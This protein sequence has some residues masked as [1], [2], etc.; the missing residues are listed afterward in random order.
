M[1]SDHCYDYIESKAKAK[2]EPACDSNE[3]VDKME[4]ATETYKSKYLKEPIFIEKTPSTKEGPFSIKYSKTCP[5]EWGMMHEH[6]KHCDC[7]LP[8]CEE[9][10]CNCNLCIE[11]EKQCYVMQ[12]NMTASY[13][14]FKKFIRESTSCYAV[15][16]MPIQVIT[17]DGQFNL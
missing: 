3:D 11:F 15:E 9:D 16:Y 8:T 1:S 17:R 13:E 10:H 6:V 14:R 5:T 7:T 2:Y 4:E 12:R